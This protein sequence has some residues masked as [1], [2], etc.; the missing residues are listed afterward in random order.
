MVCIFAIY[1]HAEFTL[2][3]FNNLYHFITS[4]G[5]LAAI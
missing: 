4:I 5:V 1:Y 2:L 3:F